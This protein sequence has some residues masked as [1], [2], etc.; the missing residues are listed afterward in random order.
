VVGADVE[1][2][3]S[4]DATVQFRKQE[5]AN[6]LSWATPWQT[7]EYTLMPPA[8]PVNSSEAPFLSSKS[9]QSS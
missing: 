4:E 8:S 9:Q 3:E 1:N 6:Y 5:L 2:A 7:S